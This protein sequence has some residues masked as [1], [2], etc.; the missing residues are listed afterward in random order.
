MTNMVGKGSNKTPI[1]KTNFQKPDFAI[2]LSC[3]CEL[4]ESWCLAGENVH[5]YK[6]TVMTQP[7]GLL[8]F[9]A[10]T[11]FPRVNISIKV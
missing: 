1:P 11:P 7:L 5:T 2:A 8:V 3:T 10:L 4:D 6:V 9:M